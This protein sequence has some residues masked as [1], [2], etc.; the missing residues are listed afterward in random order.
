VSAIR[1]HFSDQHPLAQIA[2]GHCRGQHVPLIGGVACGQCWERAIR[3]DERLVVEHELPSEQAPD[4][5]V[6][7]EVAVECAMDGRRISLTPAERRLAIERLLNRGW[8][9]AKIA[10]RLHLSHTT[11][12]DEVRRIRGAA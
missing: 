7:D 3:D 1:I 10:G 11:V 9:C 5:L 6:V 12:I 4:H 2:S 8:N